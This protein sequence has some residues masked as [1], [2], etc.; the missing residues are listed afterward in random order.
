MKTTRAL[1]FTLAGLLVLTAFAYALLNLRLPVASF[2][3]Y[4]I[5]SLAS[6]ALLALLVGEQEVTKRA[7]DEVRRHPAPPRRH[8]VQRC[9]QGHSPFVPA[10]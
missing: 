9:P 2:F 1:T 4:G 3:E 5:G 7:E 6:V 10:T 8:S